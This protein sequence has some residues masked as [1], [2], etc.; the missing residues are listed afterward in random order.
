MSIKF[1]VKHHS[2]FHVPRI[3]RSTIT[4]LGGSITID[5]II[6]TLT[7]KELSC[8][9]LSAFIKAIITDFWQVSALKISPYRK[10]FRQSMHKIV[11]NMFIR[12]RNMAHWF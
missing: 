4:V 5:G 11:I 9:I 3:F 1:R 8:Y 7:D 6:T 10:R 2:I 12:F